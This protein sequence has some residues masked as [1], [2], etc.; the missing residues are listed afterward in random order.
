MV[1]LRFMVRL[2]HLTPPAPALCLL[3]TQVLLKARQFLTT[4]PPPLLAPQSTPTLHRTTLVVVVV[5][6]QCP[7]HGAQSAIRTKLRIPALLADFHAAI[8]AAQADLEEIASWLGRKHG[9]FH[10]LV[11]SVRAAI[12]VVGDAESLLLCEQVLEA[13][14]A[15][16][17]SLLDFTMAVVM[18]PVL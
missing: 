5:A 4:M 7:R 13:S 18:T 1:R 8:Q 17:Q 2:S 14:T 6:R 16:L 15:Q 10:S 9:V 3:Q 11:E 12:R